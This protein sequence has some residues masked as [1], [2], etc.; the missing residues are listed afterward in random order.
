[1]RK[2][3][4]KLQCSY[5]DPSGYLFRQDNCLY[6][7]IEPNYKENYQKLI[8]SGLYDKLVSE[9]LLIAHKEISPRKLN[10][11]KS[12]RIIKP[13]LIPFI[14]YPYEWCFSQLKDAAL[15]TLEI[16]KKSLSKG[17]ILKDASAFNI[18]FVSG[19]PIFIDSL[20]FEIYKL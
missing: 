6:R 10:Y 14:S 4:F 12:Y 19:K 8:K 15:L 3:R 16:L 2:N 7:T 9:K 20:S 5:K 13:D 18:Q 1:M 17:M 11:K